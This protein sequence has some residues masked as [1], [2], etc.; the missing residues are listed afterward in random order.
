ML[1][2]DQYAHTNKLA[3]IN[4][5]QKIFLS[6]GA[7]LSVWLTRNLAV[8]I[9]TLVLMSFLIVYIARIPLRYYLLLLLAPASFCL[10][11]VLSIVISFTT[12][13]TIPSEVIWYSS[14]L[15]IKL[16]IVYSDLLQAVQLFYTAFGTVT[17]LYFCILTTP[18]YE[19]NHLLKKMY[20][21]DIIIELMALTYHFIFLFLDC[22]YKIYTAQQTRLGY[23][24]LKS[25]FHSLALLIVALIREIFNRNEW[26][27]LA[28]KARN[29]ESFLIP[30]AFYKK[31]LTS[32]KLTW[33]I[34]TYFSM[35][36][37][38]WLL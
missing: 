27:I 37:I 8:T 23:Q 17:C 14:I 20:I 12:S 16:F 18:M 28:M 38:L 10:L 11:G 21:P 5:N 32:T 34:I 31:K 25:S 3:A 15:N 29:I 22:M 6:I 9:W 33:M 36:L 19:I 24:T 2:I 13:S 35:T 7:L 1:S 30:T 26:M 4:A